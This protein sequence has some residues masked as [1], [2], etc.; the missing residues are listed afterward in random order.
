MKKCY[1]LPIITLILL[2]ACEVEKPTLPSW[3]VDLN[4]PLINEKFYVSDLVDSVNILTDESEV[5]TFVSNGEANTN[6][7]GTLSYT[8]MVDEGEIPILGSGINLTVP[9]EDSAGKVGV[10]YAEIVEGY[11]HSRFSNLHPDVQQISLTFYDLH[12]EYNQNLVITANPANFGNWITTNLAGLHWGETNAEQVIDE[13]HISIQV[14]PA[15]P[16]GMQAATFDFKATDTM[17]LGEFRGTLQDYPMNLEDTGSIVN[18]EYP[19]NLNHAI[20]LHDAF[21]QI[22]LT[23]YVGFGSVFSGQLEAINDEG[24]IYTLDI[25]D[26]NGHNFQIEPSPETEPVTVD[27]PF[28]HNINELLQIMPTSIRIINGSFLINSGDNIGHL[29]PT[30]YMHL[31]Y[32]ISAPLRFTLH[33]Y[34]IVI[35]EEQE[36]NIPEDNRERI[37]KNAVSVALNLDIQN[38]LPIGATAKLFFSNTPD[39][40]TH[41]PESYDFVKIAEVK[42]VNEDAG[43]QNVDLTLNKDELNVFTAE[44]V[45][46]RFA[47]SFNETGIPVTIYASTSDYIHLKGMLQ[48]TVLIEEEN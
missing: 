9:F 26:E 24:E 19:Y 18:I 25:L 36:F 8:P 28:Q 44:Q 15:L 14:S 38:T 5:L 47:F 31:D 37:Q 6:Q 39:I 12:G 13:L 10:A 16:A 33:N 34:E 48:A 46:M 17:K 21:L 23:N 30:D 7:F 1:L 22:T 4:I 40:D 43:Y 32:L 20:T 11:F 45:Y 27:I 35:Q 41:N 2:S 3:T 42:S 29:Q